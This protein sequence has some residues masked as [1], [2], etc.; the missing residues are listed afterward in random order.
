MFLRPDAGILSKT[1][2]PVERKGGDENPL[3]LS[4]LILNCISIHNALKSRALDTQRALTPSFIKI[5]DL[6]ERL[7]LHHGPREESTLLF[8]AVKHRQ[9]REPKDR[10]Y[11]IMQVYGLK[12]DSSAQPE[13]EFTLEDLEFQLVASHN[14]RSPIAAQ[15]FVHTRVIELGKCWRMDVTSKLPHMLQV[16]KSGRESACE[17]SFGESRLPKLTGKACLISDIVEVWR[18]ASLSETWSSASGRANAIQKIILDAT[19][20]SLEN[21]PARLQN[22]SL[23]DDTKQHLLGA[24]LIATFGDSVRVIL[25]GS[26]IDGV[27]EDA[28]LLAGLIV[29]RRHLGSTIC[30]QRLDICLWEPTEDSLADRLEERFLHFEGV[31]G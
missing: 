14:A 28:D 27:N 5:L 17:I 19:D 20:F 29:V 10:V 7:G 31:L 30:W 3:G 9:T 26:L 25:L 13:R 12:L 23:E 24:T 1:L 22:L 18:E 4:N 15:L 2:E 11:G 8:G 16:V 6:I 21:L